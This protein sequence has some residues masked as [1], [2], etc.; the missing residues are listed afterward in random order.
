MQLDSSLFRL[1]KR[2]SDIPVPW[3]NSPNLFLSET[4]PLLVSKG[5]SNEDSVYLTY[6]LTETAMKC[7][8]VSFQMNAYTCQTKI[9]FL[10]LYCGFCILPWFFLW[11]TSKELVSSGFHCL[12]IVQHSPHCRF[13]TKKKIVWKGTTTKK[14]HKDIR[15]PMFTHGMDDSVTIT[16]FLVW[17]DD[18]N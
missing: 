1:K 18:I 17:S 2:A 16:Y 8:L 9:K 6:I 11:F 10:F 3:I 15:L 5:C 4:F 13:Q 14:R 7:P 12:L